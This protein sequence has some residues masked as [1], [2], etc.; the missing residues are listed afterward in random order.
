MTGTSNVEHIQV[1]LFDDT[2]QMHIDEVL[3]GRCS[4]MS[5]HQRLHMRHFQRFLQQRIIIQINLADRKIIC[6]APIG[7]H[8]SQ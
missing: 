5:N 3:T 2:V 8:F 1:I 6:S 4:P 7:I